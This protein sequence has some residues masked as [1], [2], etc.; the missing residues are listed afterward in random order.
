MNLIKLHRPTFK[1]KQNYINIIHYTYL[2]IMNNKEKIIRK[3]YKKKL[4]VLKMN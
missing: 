1:M 2:S 3:N 4:Y